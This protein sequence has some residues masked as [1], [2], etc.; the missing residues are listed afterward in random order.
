MLFEAQGLVNAVISKSQ[1]SPKPLNT[2]T[3]SQ[4]DCIDL[5]KSMGTAGDLA[6][7]IDGGVKA[8]TVVQT[9]GD[10]LWIP[11]G[12][13]IAEHVTDGGLCYGVRKS[14]FI[15]GEAEINAFELMV[16]LKQANVKKGENKMSQILEV[17]KEQWQKLETER[18]AA[19]A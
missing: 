9:A 19:A 7:C 18:I 11:Q 5:I 17:M 13:F 1:T 6:M 3:V 16:K 15:M 2:D 8:L 12:Y 4:D 10:V 14:L